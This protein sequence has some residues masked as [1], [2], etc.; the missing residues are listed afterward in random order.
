[1]KYSINI[2]KKVVMSAAATFVLSFASAQTVAE[3][4]NYLDS[5]KYAKAKEVFNQLIAKSPSAE[6]YFYLG[7]AYL[8]QFE[9]NI[10]KAKE[11]KPYKLSEN[12]IPITEEKLI[13]AEKMIK[14]DNSFRKTAIAI[15]TNH[16]TLAKYLK[17]YE[18]RKGVHSI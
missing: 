7:N 6:N 10:D 2:P 16:I 18:N 4:I 8:V 12:K 9:P 13:I 11:R 14:E 5:H 15:N 1:M 3:G 17:N